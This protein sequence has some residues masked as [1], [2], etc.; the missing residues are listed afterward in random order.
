M[1]REKVIVSTRTLQW[2]CV[3]SR[4]DSNSLYYGEKVI[5]FGFFIFGMSI[6][7]VLLNFGAAM[8]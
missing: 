1:V 6:I 5:F 3:E 4:G 7:W 2:K 8:P